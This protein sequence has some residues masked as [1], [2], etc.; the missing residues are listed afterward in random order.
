MQILL[1][2]GDEWT[3]ESLVLFFEAEGFTPVA[4]ETAEEGIHA[5]QKRRYDIIITD[6]WLPFMNGLEFFRHIKGFCPG[7]LKILLTDCRMKEV[8]A[9]AMRLGIHGVVDKPLSGKTIMESVKLWL[10][11]RTSADGDLQ[12]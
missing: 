4:L 8:A 7:S 5:L 10:R 12:K 3:R 9:E 11:Q 2:N 1:V 6:Y